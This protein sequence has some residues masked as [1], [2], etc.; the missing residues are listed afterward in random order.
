MT[1]TGWLATRRPA[2]PEGLAVRIGVEADGVALH[3]ALAREGRVRLARARARLGRV[4]ESAF[5][6]LEADALVTYACEAAL[7]AQDAEAALQVVLAVSSE[8]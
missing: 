1:L 3:D 5:V 7:E 8:A 4:R 6:L 2:P